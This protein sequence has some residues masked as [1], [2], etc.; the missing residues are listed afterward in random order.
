MHL[1]R[2]GDVRKEGV[3]PAHENAAAFKVFD[4]VKDLL[5]LR[6]PRHPTNV[7]QGGDM[8]LPVGKKRQKE[9]E[10]KGVSGCWA[11]SQY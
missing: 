8:F 2:S 6:L 3:V 4:D 1:G 7:Q 9:E 11:S 5:A 10:H